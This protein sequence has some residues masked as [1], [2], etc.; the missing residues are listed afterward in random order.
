MNNN[1]K[2]FIAFLVGAGIG[3]LVT[4]GLLKKKY[5]DLAQEEINSVK[6]TFSCRVK[7]YEGPVEEMTD[8]AYERLHYGGKMKDR[9]STPYHTM[10]RTAIKLMADD[11]VVDEIA[12]PYVIPVAE[13]IEDKETYDK[14]TLYYY[15]QDDTLSGEDDEVVTDVESLIGADGLLC[16]GSLSDDPDIVYIR[17]EQLMIDYEVINIDNSYQEAILGIP[18]EPNRKKGKHGHGHGEE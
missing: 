13:F 18:G 9:P 4:S 6:E 1:T 7:P 8:E 16:F 2:N 11:E 14:I 5:E 12:L 3:A 10:A 15:N 17:N